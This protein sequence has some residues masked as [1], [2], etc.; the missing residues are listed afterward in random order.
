MKLLIHNKIT[1]K[2]QSIIPNMMVKEVTQ[3]VEYY[4][5]ILGFAEMW[6]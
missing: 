2:L 4:T 6:E 1:I 5:Q 3:S